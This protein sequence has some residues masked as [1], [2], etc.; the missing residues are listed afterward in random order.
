MCSNIQ[1][2]TVNFN[3][4]NQT[5]HNPFHS[6]PFHASLLDSSIV[7]QV[8]DE[9][10]NHVTERIDAQPTYTLIEAVRS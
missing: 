3:K 8:D 10:I 9:S 6:I 5:A 2:K 4:D 7:S 1:C